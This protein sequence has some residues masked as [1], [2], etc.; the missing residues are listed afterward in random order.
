MSC[1][2]AAISVHQC[3]IFG[4]WSALS[5]KRGAKDTV[6]EADSFKRDA[7]IAALDEAKT[8]MRI[9]LGTGSTARHFVD[10]LGDRVKQ[11]FDCICVPTSEVTAKQALQLG[12]PLASLDEVKTLDLTVDGAD[13]VDPHL[14]LIKGGG[15]A[16][17]REKI[18]ANASLRMVVI[19]DSTKY[20]QT[21]GKFPLPIEVNKFGIGVTEE[22]VRKVA[23]GF[24]P[25]CE[26]RLRKNSDGEFVETDGGHLII[27]AFF[28]RISDAK[29]LSGALLDVPGVVQHGLF[30][31]MCAAAYIAGPDGVEKLGN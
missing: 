3:V 1:E 26:V 10:L 16:L 30:L 29:A 23:H 6:N 28:G 4:I 2:H 17:L 27:D 19:A 21:L 12:I 7:A 24:S 25:E 8:G 15:A 31:N 14:N 22:Q 9:G 13:E 11:G 20:V 5:D 18:V